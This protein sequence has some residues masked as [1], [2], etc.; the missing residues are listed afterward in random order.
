MN[1]EPLDLNPSTEPLPSQAPK[2]DSTSLSGDDIN[3]IT[4]I[5]RWQPMGYRVVINLPFV[6]DDTTPLFAIKNGPY[7]PPC[8]Q[9][10]GYTTVFNQLY[11][12]IYPLPSEI[13]GGE[14]VTVTR[15]D[16]VPPLAGLLW[17]YRFWRGSMKYRFRC[18]A[19]FVAQGYVFCCVAR[20]LTPTELSNSTSSP[21][22]DI[23]A[24]HRFIPGLDVGYRQMQ[25]NS[26]SMSD[27]SMFRHIE[28]EV[29]FEYPVDFYDQY[30]ALYELSCQ[31]NTTSE[32]G[33]RF[34]EPNHGDNFILLCCRGGISSPQEGAQVVF[35][36]EYC[37]GDD[38]EATSELAFSRHYLET[39]NYNN[40]RFMQDT[41][42][43]TRMGLPFTYPTTA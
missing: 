23:R 34:I 36:L 37:P 14:G 43:S 1:P 12:P 3:F 8:V 7:I 31:I 33:Q 10:N 30:R 41:T 35:E 5:H 11:Q 15:Y 42:I 9:S 22:A 38:F 16:T 32:V 24:T 27:L 4:I 13:S 40:S 39:G 25:A 19:N 21:P 18:V 17:A 2:V 29:P 20:N 6:G 26:Y 28:V